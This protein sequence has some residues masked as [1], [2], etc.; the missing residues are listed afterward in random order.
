MRF[1]Y[2]SKTHFF[3]GKNILRISFS[4][5]IED[6]PEIGAWPKWWRGVT[7]LYAGEIAINHIYSSSLGHQHGSTALDHPAHSQET[8]WN[9]WH[10]HC[11]HN[12]EEFSKFEHRNELRDYLGHVQNIRMK[13]MLNMKPTQNVLQKIID[14]FYRMKDSY[15]KITGNVTVQDYANALAWQKAH[16]A[17]GAVNLN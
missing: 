1:I 9:A 11:F 3:I 5:G 14:E 10:I 4:S 13:R 6:L 12:G 16:S 8:I 17:V 7:S 15:E 2:R